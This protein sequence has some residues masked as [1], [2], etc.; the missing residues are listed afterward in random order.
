ML[1]NRLPGSFI[2]RK[3]TLTQVFSD[4]AI[5]RNYLNLSISSCRYPS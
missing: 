4:K 5:H 3:S 2:A 1:R